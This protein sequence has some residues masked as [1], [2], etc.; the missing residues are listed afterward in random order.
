MLS[1][2][3]TNWQTITY[4]PEITLATYRELAAHLEQVAGVEVELI[5]Q[6]STEFSYLGSQVGGLRM[7]ISEQCRQGTKELVKA[8]LSHYGHYI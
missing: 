6:A 8:I 5:P 2:Q 3:V 7:H 1:N 4:Q